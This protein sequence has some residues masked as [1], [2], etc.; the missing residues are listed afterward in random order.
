MKVSNKRWMID[1]FLI[2]LFLVYCCLRADDCK[3]IEGTSGITLSFMLIK[4]HFLSLEA[5]FAKY[6]R[7]GMQRFNRALCF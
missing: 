4:K 3:K 5:W 1:E 6:L 2:R 7:Y